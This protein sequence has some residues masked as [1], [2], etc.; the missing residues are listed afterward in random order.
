[1]EG[2]GENMGCDDFDNVSHAKFE[3]KLSG[4]YAIDLDRNQ[5]PG[6]FRQQGSDAPASWPD[7]KDRTLGDITEGVSH[8]HS[9]VVADKKMLS[10]FGFLFGS[11]SGG[12]LRRVDPLFL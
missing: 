10:Q 7:F 11:A 5:A 9:G 6:T 3:R 12:G 2:D 8:S 4:Q 1:M